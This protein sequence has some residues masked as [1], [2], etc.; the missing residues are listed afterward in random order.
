MRLKS[1]LVA[2]IMALLLAGCALMDER[3]GNGAS[4][5]ARTGG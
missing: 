5:G 3:T 4:L 2:S 1:L